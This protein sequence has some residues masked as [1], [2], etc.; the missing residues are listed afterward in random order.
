MSEDEIAYIEKREVHASLDDVIRHIP[1]D[2]EILICE[3]LT[4]DRK[5]IIRIVVAKDPALLDD[6]FE[7]RGIKDGVI[8]LTGIMSNVQK[9]HEAYPVFNCTRPEEASRL[10]DLILRESE[11][12]NG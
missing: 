9:E 1:E 2:T 8:A 10:A 6:T 5:D 3:G 12:R 7:V 11:K 4:E